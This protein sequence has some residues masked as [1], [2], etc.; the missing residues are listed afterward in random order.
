M[1]K[2]LLIYHRNPLKSNKTKK[3]LN[4][5]AFVNWSHLGICRVHTLFPQ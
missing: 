4:Y 3:V 5:I 2:S 1:V